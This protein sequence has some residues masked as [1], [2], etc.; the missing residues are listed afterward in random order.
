[1]AL[2]CQIFLWFSLFASLDADCQLR[3][4]YSKVCRYYDYRFCSPFD[5]ETCEVVKTTYKE[6]TLFETSKDE[7]DTLKNT[8]QANYSQQMNIPPDSLKTN[9]TNQ[10]QKKKPIGKRLAEK[11]K[12]KHP[13]VEKPRKPPLLKRNKPADIDESSLYEESES[14]R[15]NKTLLTLIL[16][17]LTSLIMAGLSLI[18]F[19]SFAVSLVGLCIPIYLGVYMICIVNSKIETR[20]RSIQRRNLVYHIIALSVCIVIAGSLTLLFLSL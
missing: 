16:M 1:M 9:G 8:F 13:K 18:F 17:G 12:L 20:Y 6:F 11:H 5:T 19:D 10:R 7:T 3:F 15:S 4:R 14:K 2:F